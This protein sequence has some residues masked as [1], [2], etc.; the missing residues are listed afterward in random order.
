VN[1]LLVAHRRVIVARAFG[2]PTPVRV[3]RVTVEQ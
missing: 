2:H 3:L 1:G